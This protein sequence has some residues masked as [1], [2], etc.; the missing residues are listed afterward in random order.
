MEYTYLEKKL[1]EI[2]NKDLLSENDMMRLRKIINYLQN[3]PNLTPSQQTELTT[4]QNQ[5]NA[6]NGGG[7]GQ[8]DNQVINNSTNPVNNNGPFSTF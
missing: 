2:I 3:Q 5:L 1:F 4:L 8:Q 6:N 7:F